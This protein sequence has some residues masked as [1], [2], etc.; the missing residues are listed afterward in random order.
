MI[1]RIVD[2]LIG[3]GRELQGFAYHMGCDLPELFTRLCVRTP[4]GMQCFLPHYAQIAIYPPVFSGVHGLT[5][6]SLHF[7][8]QR[9]R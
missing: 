5:T 1:K 7:I 4:A 6:G 9:L 3:T 8:E 2:T